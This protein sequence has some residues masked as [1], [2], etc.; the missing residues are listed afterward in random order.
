MS[1]HPRLV[2]KLLRRA[3]WQAALAAGVYAGSADDAR[4]GFIHF[5]TAK[6]IEGTLRKHFHGVSDL[7]VLTIDTRQIA[8]SLKW[9]PSRGGQL[10]PHL[11]APLPLAAVLKADD[12]ANDVNGVPALPPLAEGES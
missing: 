1:G 5:S 11:Y 7:I 9:E 8:E 4:D 6:Q 12:V 10:F 3:E 2:Y